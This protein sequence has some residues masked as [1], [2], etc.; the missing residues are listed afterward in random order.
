MFQTALA[1]LLQLALVMAAPIEAQTK[2]VMGYQIGGGI[3]GFIILILDLIVWC[4]CTSAL[5]DLISS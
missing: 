2:D 3:T 1:L 4:M 5:V